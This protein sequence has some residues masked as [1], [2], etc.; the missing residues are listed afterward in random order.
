MEQ[1]P[2]PETKY[3][4][5]QRLNGFEKKLELIGEDTRSA[6]HFKKQ[7]DALWSFK[8]E[9]TEIEREEI[10]AQ[11]I[12]GVADNGFVLGGDL[13]GG[14][15]ITDMRDSWAAAVAE[16]V[17]A[18]AVGGWNNLPDRWKAGLEKSWYGMRL[19]NAT[20]FATI[21]DVTGEIIRLLG[22]DKTN[23]A[24]DFFDLTGQ[25]L[26]ANAKT[27]TNS[28]EFRETY[29]WPLEKLLLT[30]FGIQPK[31]FGLYMQANM[32]TLKNRYLKAKYEQARTLLKT[33][34][35]ALE[36]QIKASEKKKAKSENIASDREALKGL[37]KTLEF[38]A[39]E[40][41]TV[42]GEQVY[43]GFTYKE[44]VTAIGALKLKFMEKKNKS[45]KS[46]WDSEAFS[47]YRRMNEATLRLRV[48]ADL[49]PPV[50]ILRQILVY[51]RPQRK[52][53]ETFEASLSRFVD[54]TDKRLNLNLTKEEKESFFINPD[55]EDKGK[56][57]RK[58][59]T[60]KWWTNHVKAS[61]K[62]IADGFDA[63]YSYAPMMGLLD[64]DSLY[65]KEEAISQIIGQSKRAGGRGQEAMKGRSTPYSI[66][67]KSF[68]YVHDEGQKVLKK[69]SVTKPDPKAAL[70][71]A[72]LAHEETLIR[73]TRSPPGKSVVDMYELWL[74]L[75]AHNEE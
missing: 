42:D 1:T 75:K 49:S 68:T 16:N 70:A 74:D 32:A 17:Q 52:K 71:G 34:I 3:A 53:G 48:E 8:N 24:R 26:T 29:K 22:L 66:G 51:S 20:Q 62:E 40:L 10:G 5:K 30:E 47:L 15:L 9:L 58:A 57:A 55:E 38:V 59:A 23:L 14:T 46:F 54:E 31:E 72:F 19:W 67:G 64:M 21:E 6:A 43:S 50:E 33:H 12:S 63:G 41:Y 45:G 56:Q 13:H 39:E 73:A 28:R 61:E 65:Y 69:K 7:I 2:N 37:R 60:L 27:K 25:I 44:A 18:V 35:E 11:M 4:T 36:K